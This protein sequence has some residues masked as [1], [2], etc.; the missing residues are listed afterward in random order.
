MSPSWQARLAS[1]LVR[2]RVRPALAAAR[3]IATI[4]AAF[5]AR[6]PVPGGVRFTAATVGGVGGEWIEAIDAPATD[7]LLYLHG[8][9]FVAC[10]PRTH[11]PITAA[12]ARQG[13]RV[14]APDY[15]LAPEH[16]FPAAPDDALAVWRALRAGHAGGRLVVA[17]ESAGGNLALGLMHALRDAG[18]PLPDACAVFSPATDLSGGSASHTLNR[19]R[20]AMFGGEQLPAL[21]AQAY[22]AAADPAQPRASPLFGDF[23][24]MPPLLIHVGDEEVLRDDALRLAARAQAAGVTVALEVYRGVPHAWQMLHRL[25][26][27]RRSIA[28]AA[29]FLREAQPT[30]GDEQLDVLIVGAG[31]SGVGAAVHLREA[32]PA[33]SVALFESRAAIGGTWD[34]FRYPGVRSDSDMYTLGYRF[35]PWRAAQAI[36]DGPSI[37]SYIGETADEHGIRP[38]VRHGHR[39]L[40]ADWRDSEGRWHVQVQREGDP[41]VRTVRARFIF[42]CG[43]Y[44]AYDRGHQPQ[45]PGE[46]AFRGRIVHPQ[47]WPADLDHAGRRVVVIGSGATAVTLVPELAKTASHVTMLQR[48]PTYIFARPSVDAIA[49]ALKRWLP[50]MLA[51]RLVRLKNVAM[52]QY[53]YRVAR[54]HP[55]AARR[56]LVDLVRAQLPADYDVARHFEP[57]YKP[58][59]QRICLVPDADLFRAIRAGRAEV[60]TD[61]IACFTEDGLVLGSGAALPADI[62]VT[63]TGLELTVLGGMRLSLDGRP[64]DPAALTVYKGMMYGGI[65]NLITTFGYTNASWTLKADLTAAYACRLL[66]HLQRHGARSFVPCPDPEVK[67]EPFLDFTSGYVQRA[68]PMLPKQGDRKPWKLHQNYTLDLL[69]LRF[70]PVDDGVMQFR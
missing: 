7:T 58:W 17:G 68:L 18:E 59:D 3:D 63:A 6:L 49:E 5:T 24:G 11:R 36:A 2:R 16:P 32:Q 20:D 37:R 44:Y 28:D 38:F 27:A 15:R 10:S 29:A 66:G 43:G 34:L 39:V 55:G 4:R 40:A 19:D 22:L 48:S 50:P 62:V 30:P 9:A 51:Y 41:A 60:V 47:F 23:A 65:P 70:S 67:P 35:K 26:E 14:F 52:Q 56:R 33:M 61:T 64:V 13:F 25:P 12:F 45:W 31:L 69:A 1:W 42:F 8:G 57:R 21:I 53:F 54:R 46:A